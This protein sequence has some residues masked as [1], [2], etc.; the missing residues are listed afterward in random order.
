[1]TDNTVRTHSKS[2]YAKLGVHS[3]Q[4]LMDLVD[5]L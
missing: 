1:M 3:K 5:S 2:A 4:E